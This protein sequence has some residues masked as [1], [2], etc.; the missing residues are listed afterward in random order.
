[1]PETEMKY[2]AKFSLDSSGLT[3]GLTGAAIS[4]DAVSMAAQ[5]G[6]AS[7]QKAFDATI[8]KALE[9]ADTMKK[10]SDVT[11]SSVENLQRLKAAGIATGVTF[12]S[13]TTT[14]RMFSQRISDAGSG[15]IELRDRLHEIGVAVKDGN[16][17][18][19]DA[20]EV[21]M[22]VNKQLNAMTNTY[23]RNNLAMATYGRSWSQIAPMIKE[24]TKAEI[25]YNNANPFSEEATERAHD[26]G[27]ELDKINA[28][29]SRM[30]TTIGMEATPAYRDFVNYF[31]T[32]VEVISNGVDK[33]RTERAKMV[34]DAEEMMLKQM[35]ANQKPM[36]NLGSRPG[37]SFGLGVKKETEERKQLNDQYSALIMNYTEMGQL[38]HDF[39]STQKDLNTVTEEFNRLLKNGAQKELDAAGEKVLEVTAKYQGLR[40]AISDLSKTEAEAQE[41]G[42][43]HV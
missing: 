35:S 18:W 32:G 29:W 25:A 7:A 37:D 16:G 14:L 31:T 36:L 2:V 9:F 3:Q 28:K 30:G 5:T 8:G 1:M 20:S 39:S 4:F 38:Q 42:R 41:I 22:D 21:F 17:Q 27:I 23:D 6:L 10:A 40:S 12:D 24:A 26:L 13:I 33:I 11:G 15:G 43:A 34:N 19:R